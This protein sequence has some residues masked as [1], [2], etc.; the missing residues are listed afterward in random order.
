MTNERVCANNIGLPKHDIATC[1]GRIAQF[2]EWFD[3]PLPDFKFDPEEPTAILLTDDLVQWTYDAGASFDWI[4][5]GSAKAMASDFRKRCRED[6]DLK[7]LFMSFD[8]TEQRHLGD[9]IKAISS[10]LLTVESAMDGFK[11]A[12]EDHRAVSALAG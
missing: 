5:V 3:L 10:G 11:I 9:A 12:V 2:C 8:E 4:F 7:K 1:E 6:E